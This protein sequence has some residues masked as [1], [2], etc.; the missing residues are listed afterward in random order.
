MEQHSQNI[1]KALLLLLQKMNEL[2]STL[3]RIEILLKE[4]TSPKQEEDN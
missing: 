1:L 3:S 2:N 4:Q